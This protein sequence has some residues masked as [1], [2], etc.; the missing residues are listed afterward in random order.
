MN[1][2]CPCCGDLMHW[3]EDLFGWFCGSCFASYEAPPPFKLKA[4]EER[5]DAR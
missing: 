2:R 4:Q 5:R 1:R 3:V